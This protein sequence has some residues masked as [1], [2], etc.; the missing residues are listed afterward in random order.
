MVHHYTESGLD[1]VFIDGIR[2]ERDDDGVEVAE[3]VTEISQSIG[4][5][6]LV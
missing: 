5:E 2:I 3:F 4:H 1:N 6:S